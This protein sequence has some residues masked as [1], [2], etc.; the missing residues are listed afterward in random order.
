MMLTAREC[1]IMPGSWQIA[2]AFQTLSCWAV[3]TFRAQPVPQ[4]YK[5]CS[6]RLH[7]CVHMR[8][9]CPKNAEAQLFDLDMML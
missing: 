6:M 1:W 5:V 8:E 9:G 7:R 3:S 2:A 4:Y